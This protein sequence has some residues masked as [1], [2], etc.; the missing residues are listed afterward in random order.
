M[1]R[2]CRLREFVCRSVVFRCFLFGRRALNAGVG[3]FRPVVVRCVFVFPWGALP[4][5]LSQPPPNK[6]ALPGRAH[7]LLQSAAWFPRIACQP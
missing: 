2:A 3:W 1:A 7:S 6:I 4:E 5:R